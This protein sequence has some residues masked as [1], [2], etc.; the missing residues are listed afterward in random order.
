MINVHTEIQ[1]CLKPMLQVRKLALSFEL[2]K[3]ESF[4]PDEKTLAF[5]HNAQVLLD[6]CAT[7]SIGG[8][9]SSTLLAQ[10][11]DWELCRVFPE[12]LSRGLPP[13]KPLG[14]TIPLMDDSKLM[15]WPLYW[16][17]SSNNDEV[18]KQITSLLDKGWIQSSFLS[19][20]AP[21][22]FVQKKDGSLHVCRLS[23]T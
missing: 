22:L 16:L 15:F 4:T 1:V 10:T 23:S 13:E 5:Q 2:L 17:S 8:G 9:S 19:F 12:D 7:H 14:H 18:R 3:L 21:I 20:G 11:V 6:T